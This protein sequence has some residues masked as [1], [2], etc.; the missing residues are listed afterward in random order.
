MLPPEPRL[1]QFIKLTAQSQTQDDTKLP[2]STQA[3]VMYAL[4]AGQE[5]AAQA[6]AHPGT[7]LAVRRK[8]VIFFIRRMNIK[9]TL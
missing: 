9:R 1:L 7:A 6:A 8:E 4:V 5:Q 2:A 3:L